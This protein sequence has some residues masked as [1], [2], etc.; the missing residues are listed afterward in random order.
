MH[1]RLPIELTEYGYETNPPNPLRGIPLPRQAAYLD[2]AQYLVWQDPRVGSL[3]QFLLLD[4]APDRAC[5]RGS[6]GYWSTFQ[7]GLVF[8]DGVHKPSYDA[9]RLPIFVPDPVAI[10]ETSTLV[11]GM[12]RPAPNGSTQHA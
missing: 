1:R 6:P 11:R 4:A 2:Q 7:T 12:L 3:A 9:Y 10:A 8:R 5:P